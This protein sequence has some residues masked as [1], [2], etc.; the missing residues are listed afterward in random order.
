MIKNKI[1]IVI[2]ILC[3][4]TFFT[5]NIMEKAA[6]SKIHNDISKGLETNK[7]TINPLTDKD[8][9]IKDK[10]NYI[11]LGGKYD[12][13][14]TNEKITSSEGPDEHNAYYFYELENFKI[15]SDGNTIDWIDLKTPILKTSRGIKIGDS[16]S[17]VFKKY[18]KEKYTEISKTT[19]YYM[20]H[21]HGKLI[22]FYVNKSRKVNGIQIELV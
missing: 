5:C 12:D 14:E 21:Y 2:S 4:G 16:I 1:L 17:T 7:D 8:F 3:I 11:E 19:G 18:G 13:L 22:T 20:Y 9:V 10:N 15:T 6:K